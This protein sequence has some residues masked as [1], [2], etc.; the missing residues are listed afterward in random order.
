MKIAIEDKEKWEVMCE[1]LHRAK[2]EL[3]NMNV[4]KAH[5]EIVAAI[6]IADNY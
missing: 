2:Q 3:E 6:N 5:E 4:G 1:H